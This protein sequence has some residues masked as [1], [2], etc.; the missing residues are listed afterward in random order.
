MQNRV[1]FENVLGM[2]MLLLSGSEAS[3][4]CS[5]MHTIPFSPSEADMATTAPFLAVKKLATS[6]QS[7]IA[8]SLSQKLNQVKIIFL[9]LRD[10]VGSRAKPS[11]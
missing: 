9:R 8:Y 11:L 10:H 1:L 6:K 2:R 7:Y 3:N 4:T 5:N